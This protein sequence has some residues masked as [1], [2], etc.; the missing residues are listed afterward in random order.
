MGRLSLPCT[1]TSA[2]R[3]AMG[4]TPA[5]R[6]GINT[7]LLV[8]SGEQHRA[9]TKTIKSAKASS[10]APSSAPKSRGLKHTL[11]AAGPW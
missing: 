8:Y 9:S 6:L 3:R 1:R 2:A 7:N 11:V 4:R 5:S 10:P